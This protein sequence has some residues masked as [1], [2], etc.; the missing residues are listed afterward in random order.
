MPSDCGRVIGKTVGVAYLRYAYVCS[1]A[2]RSSFR[3]TAVESDSELTRC[4]CGNTVRYQCL[5]FKVD[6]AL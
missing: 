2:M 1:V 3:M 6:V 5:D 4:R